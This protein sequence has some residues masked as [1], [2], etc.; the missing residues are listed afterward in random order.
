ML[1]VG[2]VM[3]EVGRVMLEVG[4]GFFNSRSAFHLISLQNTFLSKE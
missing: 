3:L 2:R 4:Q 1:E